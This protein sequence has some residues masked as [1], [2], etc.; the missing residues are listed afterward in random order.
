[1]SLVSIVGKN[2]LTNGAKLRTVLRGKQLEMLP[3][4]VKP[5]IENIENPVVHLGINGRGAEGSMYGIKV[6][7]K[8]RKEPVAAAAGRIDYRGA[9]PILQARGFVI[10]NRSGADALRANV[11]M[12]TSKAIDFE[13]MDE[14]ILAQ[15][16]G[17]ISVSAKSDALKADIFLDKA[18]AEEILKFGGADVNS[19]LAAE[20]GKIAYAS[21]NIRKSFALAMKKINPFESLTKSAKKA[22]FDKFSEVSKVSKATADV[23]AKA[24]KTFKDLM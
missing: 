2:L 7:A 12:D 18:A 13:N 5:L 19:K 20:R 4:N 23:E 11:Q 15:K 17:S 14:L 10:K 24:T 1:M 9:E 3:A 16:K 8:G 6:F 21:E 22:Q